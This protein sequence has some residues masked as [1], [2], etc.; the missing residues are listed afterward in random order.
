MRHVFSTVALGVWHMS[1][2]ISSMT[3]EEIWLTRLQTLVDIVA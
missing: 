3:Q 2:M 1:M